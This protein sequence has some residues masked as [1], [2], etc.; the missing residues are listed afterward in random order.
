MS[1][2]QEHDPEKACPGPDP[3]WIPVFGKDYAQT[4]VA[5]LPDHSAFSLARR[6]TEPFRLDAI[7]RK[8]A[9]F[10]DPSGNLIELAEVVE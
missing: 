5:A 9:F 1:S 4:I 3:G 7:S 10:A 2:S 8:L 6:L